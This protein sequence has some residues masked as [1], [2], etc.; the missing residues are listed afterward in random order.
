MICVCTLTETHCT[1]FRFSDNSDCLTALCYLIIRVMYDFCNGNRMQNS[2][3]MITVIKIIDLCFGITV[4]YSGQYYSHYIEA[5]AFP[6]EVIQ[7]KD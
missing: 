7:L 1:S 4:S 6:E 5:S 3:L 2:L